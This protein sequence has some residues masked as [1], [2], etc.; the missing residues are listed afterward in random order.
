MKRLLILIA[1][2]WSGMALGQAQTYIVVDSEQIFRSQADYTQALSTL[3][4][5]AEAEQKKVDEKF[6]EVETLYNRYMRVKT[7]LT[8]TQQQSQE[9]VILQREKEAQ[10]YQESIFGSEG[11]LMQKRVELIQPIQK[12]VFE[13][14]E[15]YAKRAGVDLVIDKSSNASLLF[16]ADRVDRTQE[17]IN[18]LNKNAIN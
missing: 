10:E 12:R 18:A 16:C 7:S 4:A 9:E 15:A 6:A 2:L 5:L 1:L 14:I 8:P 11:T 3:D 17:I 13:A